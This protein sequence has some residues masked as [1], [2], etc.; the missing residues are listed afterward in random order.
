[1]TLTTPINESKIQKWIA[2]D[3][4]IEKI[5]GELNSLGYDSESI[6]VHLKEIKKIK[7]ARRQST[8]FIILLIGASI[9]FLSCLLSL[10]NPVP[11]LYNWFLYGLTSLSVLVVFV[12]LYYLL[13]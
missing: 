12:G 5:V 4:A 10:T 9:G 13:E 6:E 8:A 11:E 3:T 2:D 1:M 7:F